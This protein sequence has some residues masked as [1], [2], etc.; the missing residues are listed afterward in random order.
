MIFGIW[1]EHRLPNPSLKYL[2]AS[3]VFVSVSA[4]VIKHNP[5]HRFRCGFSAFYIRKDGNTANNIKKYCLQ[6]LAEK[7]LLLDGDAM[8]VAQSHV[9]YQRLESY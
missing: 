7:E 5:H 9:P 1:Q 4:N 2:S 8:S 6:N 3:A